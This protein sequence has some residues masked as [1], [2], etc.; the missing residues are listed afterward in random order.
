[1]QNGLGNETSSYLAARLANNVD[2]YKSMRRTRFF[3]KEVNG[4]PKVESDIDEMADYSKTDKVYHYFLASL[5][6]H[7]SFRIRGKL[8]L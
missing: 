2:F 7:L 4:M 8:I 3:A 1:M 6:R 5:N